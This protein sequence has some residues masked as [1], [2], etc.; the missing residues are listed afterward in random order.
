MFIAQVNNLIHPLL[1]GRFV[2]ER[3]DVFH[4]V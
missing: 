1:Q 4:M 3:A 2:P